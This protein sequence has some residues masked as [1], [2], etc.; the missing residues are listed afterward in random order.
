[1]MEVQREVLVGKEGLRGQLI[2]SIPLHEVGQKMKAWMQE[3]VI[4]EKR[5]VVGRILLGILIYQI[6]L[7]LV[8]KKDTIDISWAQATR[9]TDV[10][11]M[12]EV[13]VV[14]LSMMITCIRNGMVVDERMMN[15]TEGLQ[16][17]VLQSRSRRPLVH[18]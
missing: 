7:V 13:G 15:I 14:L 9:T 17:W 2:K 12:E 10:P 6:D 1:M 11:T 18:G 8:V 3:E 5:L 4:D 16:G